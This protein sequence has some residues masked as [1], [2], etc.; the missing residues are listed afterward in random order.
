MVVGR[1]TELTREGS[2]LRRRTTKLALTQDERPAPGG[3]APTRIRRFRRAGLG[4]ASARPCAQAPLYRATRLG[5]GLGGRAAA[6][7]G[8]HAVEP[9]GFRILRRGRDLT[10]ATRQAD[11]EGQREHECPHA[12]HLSD[13]PHGKHWFHLQSNIRTRVVPRN[14]VRTDGQRVPR[15][16]AVSV[17]G[18]ARAGCRPIERRRLDRD[19]RHTACLSVCRRRMMAMRSPRLPFRF[20]RLFSLMLMLPFAAGA[21]SIGCGGQASTPIGGGTNTDA[22]P[23]CTPTDCASLA[24]PSIAKACPGGTSVGPT[25]CAREATG[26]CGWEFPACPSEP[27]AGESCQCAGP[28]PGAPSVVCSDGSMGGPVCSRSAAGTCGWQIRSCPVSTCPGLGCFPNCPNGTLKDANGCDTCQCAP[29]APDGGDAGGTCRRDADCTGG[30]LCGFPEVDACSAIGSCFAATQVR[31]NAYSPG[32]A[33]DGSEVN[34][35][36]N[37]LPNG[38]APAPLLHAGV[39]LDSGASDGGDGGRCCPASWDLYSCTYP[40]GGAGM[41]CHNPALGCASSLTCGQGCDGVVSG[42]CG[43]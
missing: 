35:I 19:L 21:D 28:T 2:R 12:A 18:R 37:G 17:S 14:L 43:P 22:G 34:A 42:R 32:C 6:Q 20:A 11:I 3:S 1:R 41:A 23:A 27:D 4:R 29:I 24:A 25:V 26:D 7:G 30:G 8:S 36:C 31:C 39:C 40:D 15:M 16:I 33:C 13:D 9:R 5:S 38:Y 10:G